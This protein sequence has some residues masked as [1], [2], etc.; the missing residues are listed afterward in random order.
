MKHIYKRNESWYYQFTVHGVRYQGA[1]GSVSKTVAQEYADKLRLQAIEGKLLT[2]PIKSP[3]FGS[4]DSI[5]KEGTAFA[6][7][8]WKYYVANHKPTSARRIATSLTA[9]CPVFGRKRLDQIDPL[10]IEKYKLQRKN[11]GKA[12]ATVNRELGCLKNSFSMAIRWRLV[13]GNPVCEI[14]M[15]KENNARQRF[16]SMEEEQRLLRHCKRRLAV[17]VIAALDTGFRA[18]ELASIR[19]RD[20]DLH[21]KEISV[22]SCYTKNGEPR[23]N[24]MT[25]RLAE[26]LTL[27][28]GKRKVSPEAFVVGA[29]RYDKAFW[30]ARD[31]AGLG[32]DVVFHTLRH[33]FISRLVMAGVDIRTVQELA[34]HKKIKMTMRYA[35]LFPDQKRLAIKILEDRVTANLTTGDSAADV[36]RCAPVAQMDR[37]SVS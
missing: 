18:S 15:F 9:L 35:H 3:V 21:R 19:W 32:E 34:G 4:F 11:D 12:D 8:Y 17:Y 28:K 26:M 5:K 23:R 6:S 27:M 20:V 33:T 10:L 2:R 22:Q 37:A 30:T 29:Y 7:D 13:T 31:K 1:I 25:A 36:S 24:P 14:K 16:L